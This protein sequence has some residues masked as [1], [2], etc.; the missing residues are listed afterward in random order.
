[1]RDKRSKHHEARAYRMRLHAIHD[2]FSRMFLHLHTADRG[3]RT[4]DPGKQH[5]Q[6]IV[7]LGRRAYC[8]TRIATDHLLLNRY[9]RRQTLNEVT[10][11]FR[12]TP[13]KLTRI[14]RQTLHIPTLPLSIKSVESQRRLAGATDPGNHHKFVTRYLDINILKIIDPHTSQLNPIVLLSPHSA[15]RF[16]FTVQFANIRMFFDKTGVCQNVLI[17]RTHFPL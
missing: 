9:R 11:R 16:Y 6:I 12:H 14:G 1:M 3:I 7:D 13:H 15:H 17:T 5:T 10:L 8:G 4:S 2:I